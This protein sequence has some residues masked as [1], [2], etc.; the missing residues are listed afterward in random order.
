MVGILIAIQ[1]GIYEIS[2]LSLF[3]FGLSLFSLAFAIL[4]YLKEKKRIKQSGIKITELIFE[5][6]DLLNRL[7]KSI[8]DVEF[9]RKLL[10]RTARKLD[11]SQKTKQAKSK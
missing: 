11:S 5:R 2:V 3:S 6:N 9:L 8:N 4:Y 10:K 1:V 7:D